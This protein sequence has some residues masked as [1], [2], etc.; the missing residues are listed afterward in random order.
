MRGCILT[1]PQPASLIT[2][3]LA[4]FLTL[5]IYQ[6]E[7]AWQWGTNP[8]SRSLMGHR[9][10]IVYSSHDF[11]LFYSSSLSSRSIRTLATTARSTLLRWLRFTWGT[12]AVTHTA[13][14]SCP[15]PTCSRWMVSSRIFH[16]SPLIFMNSAVM[17]VRGFF[18]VS[19]V[20]MINY[21]S[22]FENNN[23]G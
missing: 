16:I 3:M 17:S 6:P 15:K 20:I 1:K 14:R 13:T 10:C 8:Y 9:W 23:K 4:I 18:M 21:Y 19:H 12:T 2:L 11:L 22:H 7:R 5:T